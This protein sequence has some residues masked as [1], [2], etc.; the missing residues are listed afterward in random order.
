MTPEERKQIIRVCGKDYGYWDVP[1][2]I[3]KRMEKENH[4]LEDLE[5][6]KFFKDEQSF[7]EDPRL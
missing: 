2:A 7:G 5:R 1:P 3:R 6:K 4:Q